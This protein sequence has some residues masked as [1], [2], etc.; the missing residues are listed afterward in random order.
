M[1]SISQ[2]HEFKHFRHEWVTVGLNM[3]RWADFVTCF[4]TLPCRENRPVN[5]PAAEEHSHGSY[6]AVVHLGLHDALHVFFLHGW[7]YPEAVPHT[8]G[9]CPVVGVRHLHRTVQNH[10]PWVQLKQWHM[11]IVVRCL[12][13]KREYKQVKMN[14]K[15]CK[16]C[17]KEKRNITEIL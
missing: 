4:S 2:Y 3:I 6:L 9:L 13:K 14:I 10:R 12:R 5:P 11:I 1:P 7:W 15:K 8:K 16:E 17:K